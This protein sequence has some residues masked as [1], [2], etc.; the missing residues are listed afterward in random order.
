M[1]KRN[2]HFEP[3]HRHDEGT[4]LASI[5]L[6]SVRA[7]C[8]RAVGWLLGLV[9]VEPDAALLTETARFH[10]PQQ[11]RRRGVQRL[12]V[13][14]V[15]RIGDELQRVEAD[16][17]RQPQ[18]THRVRQARDNRLVDVFDCGE[19]GFGHTDGGQQVGHQ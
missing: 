17:I 15:H 5:G 1:V 6:W 8:P 11:Q 14:V 18:R 2:A 13:L 7:V 16:E 12:L 3:R 4:P 10:H 19:T 9:L